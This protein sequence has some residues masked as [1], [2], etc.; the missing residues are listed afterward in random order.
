MEKNIK[1][2]KNKKDIYNNININNVKGKLDY[3]DPLWNAY[4]DLHI[5]E[6]LTAVSE[7]FEEFKLSNIG[8]IGKKNHMRSSSKMIF[9][10]KNISL[11]QNQNQLY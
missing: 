10:I 4:K 7:D 11:Y 1:P 9:E 3:K 8:Q 5:S 2:S 6:A